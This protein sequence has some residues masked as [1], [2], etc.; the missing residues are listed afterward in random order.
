MNDNRLETNVFS[1]RIS[2]DEPTPTDKTM[3]IQVLDIMNASD[4]YESNESVDK[5]QEIVKKLENLLNEFISRLYVGIKICLSCET[6][7]EYERNIELLKREQMP[8]LA[9]RY[10]LIVVDMWCECAI[11][12]LIQR[13]IYRPVELVTTTPMLDSC[14]MGQ[15]IE[16]CGCWTP[17]KF[18]NST[19][20]DTP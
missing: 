16:D 13:N 4:E 9:I 5:R 20:R 17:T 12:K 19:M 6:N 7:M 2:L 11:P 1:P 15:E 8:I 10:S 14:Q 18:T 3:S